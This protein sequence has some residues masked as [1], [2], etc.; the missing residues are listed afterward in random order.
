VRPAA[1]LLGL[2]LATGCES[3]QDPDDDFETPAYRDWKTSQPLRRV[4]AGAGSE[5]GRIDPFPPESR[6]KRPDD[7]LELYVNGH[8]VGLYRVGRQPD[9]TWP[10]HSVA[11]PFQ[12]GPVNTFDLWD[13]TS[14]RFVRHA[15]DTRRSLRFRA[16][17]TADGYEIVEIPVEK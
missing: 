7:F 11:L 17:P 3:K 8:R 14:G 4:T 10:T 16:V 12:T 9:G 5:S 1:A 15:V 2:F 13:T 6:S